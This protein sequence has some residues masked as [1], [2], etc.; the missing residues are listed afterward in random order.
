MAMNG[1]IKKLNRSGEGVT[2]YVDIR[3]SYKVVE[4]MI[5]AV[6]DSRNVYGKDKK[7]LYTELLDQ[8]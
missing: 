1:T 3:L 7:T 8:V 4:S 6:D 5:A 2:I